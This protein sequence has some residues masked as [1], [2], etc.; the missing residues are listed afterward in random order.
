MRHSWN[1][2]H[3]VCLV[4][5]WT[6]GCGFSCFEFRLGFWSFLNPEVGLGMWRAFDLCFVSV[7]FVPKFTGSTH[8]FQF[9][10]SKKVQLAEQRIGSIFIFLPRI[11][12]RLPKDWAFQN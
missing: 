2:C 11:S 3:H 1:L 10:I 7:L 6:T 8:S 5:L 4:E 9:R 12:M